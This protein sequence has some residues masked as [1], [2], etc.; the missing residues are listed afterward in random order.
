MEKKI[1]RLNAIC[2][3]AS[4]E[5]KPC[6]DCLWLEWNEKRRECLNHKTVLCPLN[7]RK[8]FGKPKAYS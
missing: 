8:I 3:D 2:V 1:N 5:S 6:F 4:L 7:N